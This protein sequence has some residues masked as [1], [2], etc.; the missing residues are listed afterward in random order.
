[1]GRPAGEVE[2][3][4]HPAKPG[5]RFRQQSMVHDVVRD[6]VR[7]ALMK[8]R[9]VP[10]F[11]SEIRARPT[12]SQALSPGAVI[13]SDAPYAVEPNSSAGFQ[14]VAPAPPPFNASLQFQDAITVEANAARAVARIDH[15][16]PG[17]AAVGMPAAVSSNVSA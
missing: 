5:V 13:P 7:D 2:A 11:T 4:D 6:A 10:H 8:A 9:P 15:A 3:N 1:L 17:H 14:L 12:A 16:A